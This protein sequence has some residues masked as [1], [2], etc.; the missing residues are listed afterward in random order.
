[1]SLKRIE[2][3]YLLFSAWLETCHTTVF[4]SL[5]SLFLVMRPLVLS[6]PPPPASMQPSGEKDNPLT[7]LSSCK[8]ASSS[9][10]GTENSVAFLADVPTA[11]RFC[12]DDMATEVISPST[13]VVATSSYDVAS[14]RVTKAWSSA[15]VKYFPLGQKQRAFTG[16]IK[17]AITLLCA[18][19]T[20]QSCTSWSSPPATME[21][22]S[23]LTAKASTSSLCFKLRR[24]LAWPTA[25]FTRSNTRSASVWNRDFLA[26]LFFTGLH[27]PT[28]ST[29]IWK[30]VV[31]M[32]TVFALLGLLTST[33]PSSSEAKPTSLVQVPKVPPASLLA[34]CSSAFLPTGIVFIAKVRSASLV[35]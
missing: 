15:A 27:P 34:G 1:M 5:S 28:R 8:F 21:R 6:V 20:S 23:G 9:R 32:S 26:E 13:A 10:S 16:P 25:I 31:S 22:P 29:R 7:V 17:R 35:R 12:W 24:S 19:S 3:R 11:R 2:P 33:L 18:A 14:H 30:P 4:I